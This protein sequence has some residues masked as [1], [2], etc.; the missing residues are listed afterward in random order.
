MTHQQNFILLVFYLGKLSCLTQAAYF[1]LS[2]KRDNF[3]KVRDI[4]RRNFCLSRICRK[5]ITVGSPPNWLCWSC[6]AFSSQQNKTLNWCHDVCQNQNIHPL[7]WWNIVG[8]HIFKDRTLPI[9]I[10]LSSLSVHSSHVGRRFSNTGPF[11]SFT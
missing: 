5:S 1:Y 7:K 10:L 8:I 6:I 2:P 3:P 11:S 4:L 9:Y